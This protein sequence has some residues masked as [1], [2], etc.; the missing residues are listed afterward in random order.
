MTAPGTGS[1]A[2]STLPVVIV[3]GGFAGLTAALRLSRARPRPP[4]VLIEPRA[5]FVFLPLLY[6][7]LSGELQPWEVAP[8]YE[9]LLDGS[10]IA[11]IQDKAC[12]VDWQNKTVTTDSGHA[13]AYGQLILSTGSG[14]NDFGVPGVAEHALQFHSL[15]DVSAVRQCL[16]QAQQTRPASGG[17]TSLVIVG[18]GPTGVELACK[19]ADLADERI[20]LHLIEQGDRILPMARAFNR[21]QAE[22]ALERRKVHCH[23]NS[24]VQA[25]TETSVSISPAGDS[26][27]EQVRTIAHQGLIWT[28]GS[29]P[30]QPNLMPSVRT[31]RGRLPVDDALRSTDLPHCVV[32]GDLATRNDTGEARQPWPCTAQVAMQQ[33]A[34][35]ADTVMAIR[36][37][38]EPQSFQFN[39]LGE[40]LSLGIGQA[41]L[42]G[43]GVTLAGPL[44]FNLRRVTY[45]ARQPRLSLGLRSAGAWLLSP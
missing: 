19:L 26:A 29:S 37:N 11:L 22:A 24:R 5:R 33:G 40:M 1:E 16:K 8:S 35:A 43:M 13:I 4:I 10:G 17:S 32:I 41:T 20:Q 39:D 34:A 27:A 44:A 38:C 25:T 23:L 30:R 36:Q 3:G 28:A 12:A 15:E 45:L 7:L 18:G 2:A 9:G 21:E 6:E 31:V 14:P 42:T